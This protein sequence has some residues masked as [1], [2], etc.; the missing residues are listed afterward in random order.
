MLL[1][2]SRPTSWKLM[3][4]GAL[5]ACAFGAFAW[6]FAWATPPVGF[7][8]VNIVGPV[9][10]EEI[11]TKSETDDRIQIKPVVPRG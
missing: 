1:S 11:N 8:P 4:A 2:K 3:L 9:V 6:Q 5:V 7:T 10:L